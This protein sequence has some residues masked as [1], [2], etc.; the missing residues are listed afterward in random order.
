MRDEFLR[1]RSAGKPADIPVNYFPEGD[2]ARAPENVWRPFAHLLFRNWLE[3][4]QRTASPREIGE[5]P[6]DE[7]WFS[8]MQG[9]PAS[10]AAKTTSPPVVL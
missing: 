2:P 6:F 5:P 1:D 3:E 8:P 4:V 7:S 9:N 10:L